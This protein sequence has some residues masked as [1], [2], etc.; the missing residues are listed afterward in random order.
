MNDSGPANKARRNI[1]ATALAAGA[2]MPA[3][4]EGLG[5][6][7]VQ[8]SGAP[9][10]GS[11]VR[12]ATCILECNASP[13]PDGATITFSGRSAV[14]DGG[15]GTFTYSKT[16][17]HAVDGGMVFA[18]SGGGRLLRNGWTVFGFNGPANANWWGARRDGTNDTAACQAA[19]NATLPRGIQLDF[20]GHY[21]VDMLTVKDSTYAGTLNFSEA[22]FDGIATVRRRALLDIVNCC[23]LKIIRPRFGSKS[24]PFYDAAMSVRS[25]SGN[26]HASTRIFIDCPSFRYFKQAI[27]FGAYDVK[28]QCS[29]ITV[30]GIQ[31][32]GCPVGVYVA[33]SQTGVAFVGGDIV[34][35]PNARFPGYPER[36]LWMEGGFVSTAATEFAKSN[37]ST[38]EMIFLSPALNPEF[39]NPYPIL[40][41]AGGQLETASSLITI[42]NPRKVASPRSLESSI[43]IMGAG[44]YVSPASGAKD[45]ITNTDPGYSGILY[46]TG[47]GFYCV[48]GSRTGFNISSSSPTMRI[49]TDPAFWGT[50]FLPW[51]G[52]IS[53]G[54]V[55][56]DRQPVVSVSGLGVTLPAGV[57]IL[58]FINND[59]AANFAR[60]GAC[61]NPATGLFTVPAGGFATLD[62][63]A[64][65][66]GGDGVRGDILIRKNGVDVKYG[67]YDGAVGT[68]SAV[69]HKLV[70]G[71]SIGIHIRLTKGGKFNSGILQSLEICGSTN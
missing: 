37:T 28:W 33:G 71:D 21:A 13:L 61:Y 62:I 38:G 59:K 10:V 24:N 40:R 66:V 18:P 56:H 49:V 42:A 68:V 67:F 27:S 14:N 46:A 39:N 44:G 50:G 9:L 4:G 65:I 53:G 6:Q 30:V 7:V 31:M 1:F 51:L 16:A 3:M 17:T 2:A 47:P 63:A 11:D 36:A 55:L 20:C 8:A 5:K 43:S 45:F 54:I 25:Q 15:G 52:G 35:E 12:H 32:V 41:I 57:S 34:S 29:E 58:K 48:G 64:G 19:I 60:Y 22:T 70:A 26:S 23:G 69:L